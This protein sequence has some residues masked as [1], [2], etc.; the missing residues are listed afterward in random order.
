[1]R[2]K[3]TTMLAMLACL[4]SLSVCAGESPQPPNQA[5]YWQRV[6]TALQGSAAPHEKALAAQLLALEGKPQPVA[7]DAPGLNPHEERAKQLIS[8]VSR[9]DTAATLAIAT[10]AALTLRDRQLTLASAG[11]WQAIEGDNLAPLLYSSLPAD[12]MLVV[13]REVNRYESHGYE[14]VRLLSEIFMRMPMN[15]QEAGDEAWQA[16]PSAQA[17]AAIA[18]FAIWAAYGLPELRPLVAACDQQALQSTAKRR[19]D[20]LHVARTLATRSDNIAMTQQGI[21]LLKRVAETPE[22]LALAASLTREE[23][24]RQQKYLEVLTAQREIEDT[25][26]LL[27]A[28]GIDSEMQLRAAMLQERGI[29]LAPPPDWIAP[30]PR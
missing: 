21:S 16:Y 2:N 17:Q 25:M 5:L 7:G 28:P 24:W 6:A 1:M 30:A 27:Y 29:A 14:Q 20:C 12:E 18:A 10:Q 4:A 19:E 3:L 9:S 11:R 8:Q 15:R 26:R 13:A 22:D 23:A